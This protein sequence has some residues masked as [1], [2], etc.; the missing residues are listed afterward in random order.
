MVGCREIL[1]SNL[2]RQG[3]NVTAY[4]LG[5]DGR[6]RAL[7]VINRDYVDVDFSIQELKMRDASVLRMSAPA[8]ESKSNVTLG[9]SSVEADGNWLAKVREKVVGEVVRVPKMS[10]A[11]VRA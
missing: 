4:V 10:A 9:G 7:V 2:D 11:V 8:P 5:K 1:P 3:I 6:P